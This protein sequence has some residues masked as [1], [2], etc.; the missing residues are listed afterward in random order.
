M[1]AESVLYLASAS[2]R[3]RELLQ[4]LGFE[5]QRIVAPIDETRLAAETPRQYV[6]RL[7]REKAAAGWHMLQQAGLPAHPVLAADTTVALGDEIF[8]KPVDAADARAM[9]A[10]LAGRTHQVMTAVVVVSAGGLDS[11]LVISEVT[12]AGGGKSRRR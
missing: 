1:S 6:E 12:F 4:Q 11:E 10:R 9:L 2:P 5:P 3:R 7:A 8:G